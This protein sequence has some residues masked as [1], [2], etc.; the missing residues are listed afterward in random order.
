MLK[1][2]KKLFKKEPSFEKIRRFLIKELTPIAKYVYNSK[3]FVDYNPTN[4]YGKYL[5]IQVFFIGDR[6]EKIARWEIKLLDIV[7]WMKHKK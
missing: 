3:L 5:M 2:I 7:E 6:S 1:I 4:I